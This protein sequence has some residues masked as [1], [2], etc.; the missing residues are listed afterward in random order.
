[1]RD[2][3]DPKSNARRMWGVATLG[4][5]A[6]TTV[7]GVLFQV[8]AGR[9]DPVPMGVAAFATHETAS[10][11]DAG[12]M[13]ELEKAIELRRRETVDRVRDAHDPGEPLELA[14]LADAEVDRR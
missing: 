5:L 3:A 8:H 6:V 11:D 1:M 12:L 7:G 4:L 2:A 9:E 10:R 13:R 14:T